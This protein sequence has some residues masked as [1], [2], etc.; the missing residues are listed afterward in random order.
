M[1]RGWMMAILVAGLGISAC[2]T[3]DHEALCVPE[4]DGETVTVVGFVSFGGFSLVSGREFPVHLLERMTDDPEHYVIAY[5]PIG[6]DA[7]TMDDL[8]ES[9]TQNDIR[10]RLSEGGR[11]GY[12]R[13]IA[14]TG[15]LGVSEGYC[16]VRAI[17]TI[18]KP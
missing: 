7:G 13:R 9:F 15:E 10:I 11:R 1:S 18:D 16:A 6:D 14:V 17:E 12:G 2:A 3:Y 8:P 4:N 5:I